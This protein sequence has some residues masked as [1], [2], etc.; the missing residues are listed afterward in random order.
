VYSFIVP[1]HDEEASIVPT[2]EAIQSSARGC[3]YEV[4]VVDDASTDRT[5]EL[6]VAAGARL[7]SVNLRQIGAVRN[8]GAQ[9]AKG[10]VFVF[11]DADTRINK[12][13]LQ[14]MRD[15]LASG[16]IGGGA[17]IR[18]DRPLPLWA[19]VL[20]PIMM[21]AYFMMNL[22]AGCFLFTTREAFES[23]GGFDCDLYAGE[24]IEL[25]RVLKHHARTV[26]LHSGCVG[27]FVVL[28]Q[29][30]ETSAR[31]LRTH[32]AWSLFRM[33]GRLLFM[34]R[35]GVASRDSLHLWYGPRVSDPGHESSRKPA[36][37]V[38]DEGREG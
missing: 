17:M 26:K 5:A 35:R 23:V 2:I 14:G 16:A 37:P 34:G 13:V 1:A 15:A 31:K 8:A 12:D 3:S 27:R 7:V 36:A 22:A 4:L 28:R 10:E 9:A 19:H 32:S 24:E 21:R 33:M 30:V 25:S 11:V 20:M 29:R 38:G 6:A 18:L